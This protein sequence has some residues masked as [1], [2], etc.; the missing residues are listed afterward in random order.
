VFSY[1]DTARHR[2]GSNFD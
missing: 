1:N 2:L